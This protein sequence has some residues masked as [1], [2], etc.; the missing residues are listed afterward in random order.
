M[1]SLHVEQGSSAWRAGEAGDVLK[2]AKL[3]ERLWQELE[4]G[5]RQAA[6]DLE[7]ISGILVQW[8]A[9]FFLTLSLSWRE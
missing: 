2:E 5:G 8:Y 9:A 1:F 7:E 4:A 6:Q 3:V